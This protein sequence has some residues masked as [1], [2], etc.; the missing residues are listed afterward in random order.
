M[1]K[2]RSSECILTEG[3]VKGLPLAELGVLL[4]QPLA[5]LEELL[6]QSEF[7]FSVLDD[8]AMLQ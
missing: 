6:W 8:K 7:N 3:V 4:L 1:L 5:G 2:Q